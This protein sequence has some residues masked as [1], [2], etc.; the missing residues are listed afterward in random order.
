MLMNVCWLIDKGLLQT[1][2]D[3][4]TRLEDF[5]DERR[6]SRL[7]EKFIL[8]Y[9]RKEHPELKAEASYIDWALDDGFDDMLS[10]MHSDIM[11]TRGGN[12]LIIDAKYYAHTMQQ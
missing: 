9:Y 2:A 7:Y 12:V 6:M 8:M 3:G 5:L 11:L 1:Q 4:T 10:A